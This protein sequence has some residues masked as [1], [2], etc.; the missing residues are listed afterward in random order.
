MQAPYLLFQ[1]AA[2]IWIIRNL[3]LL[4]RLLGIS[5]MS[6]LNYFF[7]LLHWRHYIWI[8]LAIM[9][10]LLFL[11]SRRCILFGHTYII[12]LC[13]YQSL[14]NFSCIT[15]MEPMLL[16]LRLEGTYYIIWH[17]YIYSRVSFYRLEISYTAAFL[18]FA[19]V[20]FLLA[21]LFAACEV[22]LASYDYSEALT[23]W[24][25]D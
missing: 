21:F 22:R 13:T 23:T 20:D 15:I 16:S 2:F 14:W 4:C 9:A 3:F 17:M 7:R 25:L 5:I 11:Y 6:L 19:F 10:L 24:E 12:A 1:L 18:L 8:Y